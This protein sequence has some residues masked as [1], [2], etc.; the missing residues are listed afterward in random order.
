MLF[1]QTSKKKKINKKNPA[2]P[3]HPTEQQLMQD[4]Y[5]NDDDTSIKEYLD[6]GTKKEPEFV[7]DR[8]YK[9]EEDFLLDEFVPRDEY[10]EFSFQPPALKL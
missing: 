2:Y 4:L 1:F 8:S 9:E 10:H 3:I 5:L 7:F 6:F